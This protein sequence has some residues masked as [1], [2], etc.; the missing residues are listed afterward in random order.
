[1]KRI[2]SILLCALLAIIPALAEAPG[3]FP[4]AGGD[5][6][7][8]EYAPREDGPAG[9]ALTLEVNGESVTLMFDNSSIYSSVQNGLVQASYS[10]YGSDGETLYVLYMIFPDTAKPGMVITPE[11]SV[12]TGGDSS[13]VLIISNRE[14][15]QYYFSSAM[16]GTLYPTDSTFSIALDSV[17]SAADGTTYAGRL[18]ATLI[19]LDMVSGSEEA[20]LTIP[21]TAFSFTIIGHVDPNYGPGA[22]PV[23]G[24]MRK[25]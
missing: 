18:S 2:L 24:D 11:Y 15:E 9:E 7:S 14:R 17:E 23:P 20:R 16:A 12:L 10:A 3:A 6:F 21:D 4:N 25:V 19:S 5:L 1:M 8:G 13:V 22:S